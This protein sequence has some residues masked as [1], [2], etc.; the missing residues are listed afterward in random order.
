MTPDERA[1]IP[2][3]DCCRTCVHDRAYLRS[4][5]EQMIERHECDHPAGMLQHPGC[6]GHTPRTRPAGGMCHEERI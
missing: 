3:P 4:D 5:G 1:R 6:G 2:V